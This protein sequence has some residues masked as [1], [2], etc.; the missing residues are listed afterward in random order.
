MKRYWYVMIVV[1]GFAA[2]KKNDYYKDSGTH[3]PNFKGN[4]LQYLQSKPGQFDS[5]AKLIK[6]AGMESVFQNEEITFFAPSDSSIRA[7]IDITNMNLASIGLNPINRMDQI[8]PAVWRKYLALYLFKGAK[9]LND[10]PQIDF[11]NFSAFSGQIYYSYDGYP[12]NIGAVYQDAGGIKYAGYRMLYLSYIGSLSSPKDVSTWV[13]ISVASANIHPSNGY[14]H[15][16]RYGITL[17]GNGG[18][19][20]LSAFGFLP[21]LLSLDAVKAGINY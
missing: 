19:I 14:V 12:M 3:D 10:Y 2:C 13:S 8:K 9:S 16:L 17:V 18:N 4:V 7:S 1:L 20:D 15:A 21:G 5:V 6:I 11:G